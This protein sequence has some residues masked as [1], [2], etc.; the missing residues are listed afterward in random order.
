V[1]RQPCDWIVFAQSFEDD[2][3]CVASEDEDPTDCTVAC[4]PGW[5]KPEPGAHSFVPNEELDE[6]IEI[7]GE[8]EDG[9]LK[10]R[11]KKTGRIGYVSPGALG[12]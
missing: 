8:E 11:D 10:I 1:A 6:R 4:P 12:R 5:T 3:S 7:L 2:M 9:L